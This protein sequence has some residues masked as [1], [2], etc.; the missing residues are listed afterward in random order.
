MKIIPAYF[1]LPNEVVHF[2]QF[3]LCGTD[4]GERAGLDNTPPPTA[5]TRLITVGIGLETVRAEVNTR[6]CDRPRLVIVNSGYRSPEVN[7]LVGSS[8]NSFHI[9]GLAADIRVPGVS[10]LDLARL[11]AEKLPRID[12]IILEFYIPGNS[13]AGWVHLQWAKTGDTPRGEFYIK[14]SGV[15]GYTR[16]EADFVTKFGEKSTALVETPRLWVKKSPTEAEQWDGTMESY[17]RIARLFWPN[18]N[19]PLTMQVGETPPVLRL[20]QPGRT[21]NFEIAQAGDYIARNP[22][23]GWHYVMPGDQFLKVY[24]RMANREDYAKEV[25]QWQQRQKQVA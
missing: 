21:P 1:T 16:V 10:H 6:F 13:R 22:A 3:E 5:A 25:A 18:G 14:E 17:Q 23:E 15:S 19:A 24:E 11:C 4:A 9:L 20:E 8:P 12:K 2:D 7:K